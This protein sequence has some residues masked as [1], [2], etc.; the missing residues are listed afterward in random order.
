MQTASEQ[1]RSE[2]RYHGILD[3]IA[4]DRTS[5]QIRYPRRVINN[6]LSDVTGSGPLLS[7]AMEVGRNRSF[8]YM[9]VWRTGPAARPTTQS[10]LM[11][12][13]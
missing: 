2:L 9:L 3:A 6:L 8:L 1:G 13:H 12:R 7:T 11:R 4:P 10:A 5:G